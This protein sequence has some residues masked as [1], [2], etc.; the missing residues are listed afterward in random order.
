MRWSPTEETC[1]GPVRTWQGF[2]GS[3]GNLHEVAHPYQV[4]HRC[5]K[6]EPPA[7]PLRPVEFDLPQQPHSL[8]SAENL[9]GPFL[10][11]DGVAGV[12]C[13]PAPNGARPSRRVWGDMRGDLADPQRVHERGGVI[14][15]IASP[16][17]PSCRRPGV[18]Q[19]HGGVPLR[20]SRRRCAPGVDH[21][22]VPVL[23]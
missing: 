21:Q 19:G 12:P 6:G 10:L 9:F 16:R 3:C 23:Y 11:T 20:S 1:W 18:D 17:D 7:D 13:G 4:I 15:F 14:V 8:Q 2:V 22:A 5:R